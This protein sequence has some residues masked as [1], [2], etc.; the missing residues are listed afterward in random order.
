VQSVTL[1][2]GGRVGCCGCWHFRPAGPTTLV[3]VVVGKTVASSLVSLASM[4]L[5]GVRS[6]V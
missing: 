1:V 2:G 6:V 5:L 4:L 3:T